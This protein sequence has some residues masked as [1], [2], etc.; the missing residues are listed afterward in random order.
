M[1]NDSRR[2]L[3]PLHRLFRLL[4]DDVDG[5][6]IRRELDRIKGSVPG[7][8][9]R[10]SM[11]I[12]HCTKLLSLLP[13]TDPL[14]APLKARLAQSEKEAPSAERGTQ[15]KVRALRFEAQCEILVL[16]PSGT[17]EATVPIFQVAA[18]YV[19]GVRPSPGAARSIIKAYRARKH[20]VIDGE[21]DPSR[22]G[23]AT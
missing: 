7:A 12:R 2:R 15:R 18:A 19:F 3:D 10:T 14:V 17:I 23:V 21:A 1:P 6:H 4:G 9:R 5:D 13:P 8:K 22:D 11:V 16:L 20:A